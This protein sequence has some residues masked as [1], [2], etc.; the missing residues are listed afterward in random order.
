MFLGIFLSVLPSKGKLAG[1]NDGKQIELGSS[2][3]SFTS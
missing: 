3:L 2:L 1:R